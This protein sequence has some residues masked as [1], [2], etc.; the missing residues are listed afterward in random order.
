[1]AQ[2]VR[3]QPI[4]GGTD[5]ERSFTGVDVLLEKLWNTLTSMRF[6]L[7]L[8]LLMAAVAVIGALVV[9]APSGVLGDPAAKADW[10][11]QIRPKY[12]GWTNIM[13]ALSLFA[14]FNS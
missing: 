14:V 5:A 4:A 13:D 9:Q 7:I 8:M 11:D 12:G 10:L 6:A 2:D 1:M 3:S